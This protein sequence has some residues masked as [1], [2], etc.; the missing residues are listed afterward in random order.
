M[1]LTSDDG[2]QL[3][4]SKVEPGSSFVEGGMRSKKLTLGSN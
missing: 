3:A 2:T 1:N 4:S